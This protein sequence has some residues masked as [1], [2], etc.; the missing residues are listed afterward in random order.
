MIFIGDG[1]YQKVFSRVQ[2]A[3]NKKRAVHKK[4]LPL[5]KQKEENM[6]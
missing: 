3:P 6:G 2:G 1:L 4:G 5:P